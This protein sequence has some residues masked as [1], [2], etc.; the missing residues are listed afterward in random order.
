[1]ARDTVDA[2]EVTRSDQLVAWFEKGQKPREAWRIG[3]EHEKFPFHVKDLSPVSYDGE[4]GIRAILEALQART[5]WAPILDRDAIIGLYDDHGG[6]AISLEPGGQ[7]ELSGAPLDDIHAAAAELDG[8]LAAVNAIASDM[9]IAFLGVGTSPL[10]S[11]DETPRMP[12]SRYAIMRNYMPKVG[13]RGLDMMYR[14]STVQV[15]LDFTSEADMVE[16]MRVSLALQPLATALFAASPFLNGKPTGA[17][18]TRA[19]IWLDTDGDR[20]GLLPFAFERGFGFERYADWALDV[21][22]YFVK[23]GETY[24]DV[25]GTTFREFMAGKL[26]DRLPGVIPE[27]GDWTN[28]LGTLFP[29]ARL[30]RYIEQRGADAGPRDHLVALPAFWTGLLYDSG[31]LDQALQ[32]VRYWSYGGLV[33]LRKAVATDGLRTRFDRRTLRD[34][35]LDVLAL[36]TEGLKRRARV[37]AAGRDETQHLACLKEIAESGQSLADRML[38]AYEDRGEAYLKTLFERHVI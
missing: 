11:Y 25:T 13:T 31:V 14:T 38:A 4:A 2:E 34:I 28:H 16:K 3:T 9:G 29:E 18:S 32:L 1:M 30:K 35:A 12:K 15:N 22:M 17:L 33:D 36:A 27:I 19:E 37:D 24:H 8:H 21:P 20:T 7:F 23:R 5:G 26:K 10:W 6:G